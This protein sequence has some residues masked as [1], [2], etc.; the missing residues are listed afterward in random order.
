MPFL[1]GVRSASPQVFGDY[2]GAM[3]EG[4]GGELG[5]FEGFVAVAVILLF[6]SVLWLIVLGIGS[7][8]A[9]IFAAGGFQGLDLK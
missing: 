3:F 4:I 8:V 9:D 1:K 5:D 6:L 7:A 2:L